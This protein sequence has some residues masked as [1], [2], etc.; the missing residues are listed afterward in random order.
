MFYNINHITVLNFQTSE[1]PSIR[2]SIFVVVGRNN[3]LS[4]ID[5]SYFEVVSLTKL[6]QKI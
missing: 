1:N 6:C 3:P 2:Y 5:S 4:E